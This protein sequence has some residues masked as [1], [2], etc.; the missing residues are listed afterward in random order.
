[1]SLAT[2]VYGKIRAIL[3]KADIEQIHGHDRSIIVSM[4]AHKL[5]DWETAE[6]IYEAMGPFNED[7]DS[8][9]AEL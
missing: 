4:V 6:L 5:M 2:D 8:E 1:M 7:Y 3:E 9:G